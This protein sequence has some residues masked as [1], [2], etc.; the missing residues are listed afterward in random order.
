[1]T[2]IVPG[3][4]FQP[5]V[6]A[7]GRSSVTPHASSHSGHAPG[8][9]PALM[10]GGILQNAGLHTTAQKSLGLVLRSPTQVLAQSSVRRMLAAVRTAAQAPA[11]RKLLQ[12]SRHIAKGGGDA[13]TMA[14][15]ESDDPFKQF[16]ILSLAAETGG[17]A[18]D[19]EGGRRQEDIIL[20]LSQLE[21][22]HRTTIRAK[23]HALTAALAIDP[24]AALPQ[25]EVDVNHYAT[26]V[27]GGE[28]LL[29]V[30]RFLVRRFGRDDVERK[31]RWLVATLAADLQSDWASREVRYLVAVR[32]QL[33]HAQSLGTILEDADAA[34]ADMQR[35]GA[36]CA[37]DSAALTEQIIELCAARWAS[38][39]RFERLAMQFAVHQL[40]W[41]I[42]FYKH[43]KKIIGRV[44]LAAFV[45]AACRERLLD[46]LA[47]ASDAAVD[48]EERRYA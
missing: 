16:I 7:V 25:L 27:A 38:S 4:N 42:R 21:E 18:G 5:P 10:H 39:G 14:A 40:N 33:H 1:M 20:A 6:S 15:A 24:E 29:A 13:L 23:T 2:T 48:E 17:S 47:G 22:D 35:G 28:T 46:G 8:L 37:R 9:A 19:R 11:N 34:L 26:L 36:R 44:P 32:E 31:R 45:D 41:R 43:L 3:V 30:F 12:S